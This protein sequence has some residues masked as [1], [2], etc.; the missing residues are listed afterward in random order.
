MYSNTPT[1][2][3]S[4]ASNH[5]GFFRLQVV[6]HLP[7]K[8][9][10][11][12]FMFSPSCLLVIHDCWWKKSC[13]SWYGES[14]II[15]SVFIYLRWLFGISEPSTVCLEMIRAVYISVSKNRAT[16]KWMVYNGK[17]YFNGWFGGTTIFGNTHIFFFCKKNKWHLPGW[18]FFRSKKSSELPTLVAANGLACLHFVENWTIRIH[19][20]F[21]MQ[22]GSP[23]CL[24]IFG[25]IMCDC[26]ENKRNHG[27]CKKMCF[28]WRETSTL[29]R[30]R[31]V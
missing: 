29:T 10:T 28:L 27:S 12:N 2:S 1:S 17:P 26:V 16:P 8:Q 25:S 22:R 23:W 24:E 5:L 13:T 15:Y 18:D 3:S 19:G 9:I 30:V 20:F 4:F 21:W 14:T 7:P 31:W 6:F 11:R